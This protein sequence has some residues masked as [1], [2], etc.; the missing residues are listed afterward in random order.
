M[1][2]ETIVA[3]TMR[4][5]KEG[6]LRSSSGEKVTDRN[7]AIAIALSKSGQSKFSEG[8]SVNDIEDAIKG[9][10]TLLKFA[11]ASDKKEIQTFIKGLEILKKMS[12]ESE[13][14]PKPLQ[15]VI[16]VEFEFLSTKDRIVSIDDLPKDKFTSGP[17][18]PQSSDKIIFYQEGSKIFLSNFNGISKDKMIEEFKNAIDN[19]NISEKKKNPEQK[20]FKEAKVYFQQEF[21]TTP[22]EDDLIKALINSDKTKFRTEKELEAE[23]YFSKTKFEDEFDNQIKTLI[24]FSKKKP[25]KKSESKYTYALIIRPF[26]IGTYPKENFVRFVDEEED[27]YKFGLLEYSKPIPDRDL[28]HYSLAP[29][30]ELNQ[31]NEKLFEYFDGNIGQAFIKK[32]PGNI[33]YVK[34]D[35]YDDPNEEAIETIDLSGY[36]FLSKINSGDYKIIESQSKL[37]DTDGE[38]H[39]KKKQNLQ[40]IK[41]QIIDFV[42]KN[43]WFQLD[44]DSDDT[45][46]FATR[47]NGNVGSESPG[48]KDIAEAKRLK[49]EIEKKFEG[50]VKIEL[51]VVDEWVHINIDVLPLPFAKGGV[52][53]Q[54]IVFDDNGEENKGVIK[55]I[56]EITGDY[57]VATDDGRT[58]L[59]SKELDVIS[60]GNIRKKPMESVRKRFSFFKDGGLIDYKKK[61]LDIINRTNPA[62]NNINTWIRSVDDIKTAEEVFSVA[63][64]EGAMYPDFQIE[65]MQEALD[66]GF[67]TIYSSYPIKPGVF[68]T[69]S[70]MNATDYAGGNRDKIHSKKVKL[71]E[72]AWIDESEGQY[73][74]VNRFDNGGSIPKTETILWAVKIGEPDWKEQIITTDPNM[75][76]PAKKWAMANGFDRFR[77][78]GIDMSS[79]PDFTKTFRNGGTTSS[80]YEIVE[81]YNHYKNI[82]LYRVTD[83]DEYVGEWHSNKSD[84]E[85]ELFGLKNKF[86]DGGN[87]RGMD[88]YQMWN[89]NRN[90]IVKVGD[91][92]VHQ[93]S[94]QPYKI[95]ELLDDQYTVAKL[96]GNK[97]VE[98]KT[99][100]EDF[101]DHKMFMPQQFGSG[102]TTLSQYIWNNHDLMIKGRYKVTG[103][104]EAEVVVAGWE[105]GGSGKD[106]YLSMYQPSLE[107][108]PE[109]MGLIVKR[110]NLRKMS[111]GIVVPATTGT[112]K[113]VKIQRIGGIYFRNDGQPY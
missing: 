34:V 26:D 71:N 39:L 69:P 9:A 78:V 23:E 37:K 57:I 63:Y 77:I 98:W 96:D 38:N 4:E 60:L 75:I 10:K 25:S 54:E 48:S 110:P 28:K 65:D 42:E 41:K 33:P 2:K 59:A 58:V 68:V 50:L 18:S 19:L 66:T 6:K 13:K 1:K 3:N 73:A 30:S 64:E 109:I 31:Y 8:G 53:G 82:P 105:V 16:S 108:N 112:G 35:L 113:K 11:S 107:Q 81:G 90:K 94:K 7:Q 91:I 12:G 52:I 76:E 56:H 101:E 49:S 103:D 45:L 100:Y 61:Q 102:G 21:D 79:K 89:P 24:E 14:K 51:E 72:I 29:V 97:E 70:A 87:V 20:S 80:K 55:D 106:E 104:V 32:T 47:E 5:F 22:K 74:P 92:V 17:I 111:N 46:L 88:W 86:K 40:S 84:A 93:H 67:V 83:R 95:I 43:S 62:P 36:E 44:D 85:K 27:N 15:K 99:F